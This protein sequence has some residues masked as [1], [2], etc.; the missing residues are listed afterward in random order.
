MIIGKHTIGA[1][2]PCFII[3]EAGV[4]HNGSVALAK[5]LVDA[6]QEAGADAVKFQTFK[7]ED[8]CTVEAAQAEYQVTNTGIVES[9][10]AMLKRL[11]LSED[12]HIELKN[13]CDQKKI[14][15]CS[16]PHSSTKDADL[17]DKH[18]PFFKIGSGD[19][20]NLPMLAH[21]SQKRKPIVLATG[22]ATL[23]EVR[24]AYECIVEQGNDTV[25]IVHA[26]SNYP[27]M[28]EEAN[29]RVLETL[30]R[31]IPALIGY[32]DNGNRFDV[33]LL[34]ALMGATVIEKHFTLDH[35]LPG[36]D[37]IASFEPQELALLIKGIKL[38]QERLRQLGVEAL[39]SE[40]DL[41]RELQGVY[42]IL[43]LTLDPRIV[44]VLLGTGVKN[45]SPAELRIAA[46]ARKSIVA[47]ADLPAGKILTTADLAIKRPGTGL[48][49]KYMFGK[50]NLVLGKRLVKALKRDHLLTLGDVQ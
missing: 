47:A 15:F 27:F 40:A 21:V 26:T 9:Q 20:T 46:V 48:L 11:E 6:A 23:E 42:Q 41:Q 36:P 38:C 50:F 29:L 25:V 45:P 24:E 28:P 12:A 8:I 22:M 35:N 2:Q 1:G 17:L 13:Y 4:N 32:S 14:I 7:A 33:P 44:N 18:V 49:P 10:Q 3:A 16:T 31:E 43:G 30:R 37:H 19:L 5:K 39:S 34:A